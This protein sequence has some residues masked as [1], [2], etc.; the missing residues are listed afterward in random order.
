M[1]N[2]I[3]KIAIDI[4]YGDTKVAVGK[5]VFKFASAISKQKEAQSEYFEGKNEG[6]YDFLGKKY[7]VGDN[8]LFEAVSTRGFDFLVKYSPL[9][10]YHAIKKAN[11][12]LSKDIHIFTGLSIVNWGEKERFLE[13]LKSIKVDNDILSPK[14]TLMAQGQGVF[15]DYEKEKE[16]LVCVVD[17]GYNTFDFLVFDNGNPRQDLSFATKKGAN[18]IITE[19]QN[20]IK[21][22]YSLDISEQS[23]KD[24]FQNGFIEIYGE[25]ID[26]S[27]SIDD[28]KEEYSEFIINE[29]RNQRE[30]IVKTAKRVIFS[31]GGAYFL[32]NVKSLKNV[33]NVDFSDKP[34]EYANVKGYLKWKK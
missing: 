12:D 16:G 6:V 23:S 10:V 2:E 11:L 24:I 13:S 25:K 31:G 32:D 18:V 4:G 29:L 30:D 9:L 28:L 26:L 19:L 1:A 8:A 21:K 3:Q 7:F 17:I 5:E 27:D 15:C 20:I 33:K 14:I 22:R 34:Y